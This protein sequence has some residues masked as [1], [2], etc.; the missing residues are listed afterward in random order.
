MTG[1][2]G[3][4]KG[5]GSGGDSGRRLKERL[6]TARGRTNSSQRWLQRQINDPYAAKARAEGFRSRAAYK[7]REIDDKFHIFAPGKKVIDLGA[8][9]GGWC[10]IA[11][12]RCKAADGRGAVVA[13]DLLEMGSIAGV[14]FQQMD[15][16]DDAAPAWIM[17]QIGGKADVVLSDMAP[18]TTGHK[19]TDHLR[20]MGLVELAADFATQVLAPGGFFVAKVF[21]GGAQGEVLNIL[22]R[23]FAVVKHV[24]PSSSRADSSELFLVATGFRGLPARLEQEE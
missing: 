4:G 21:Q 22:K 9:P 24:K 6:R 23:A 3:E 1:G 19:A 16:M 20:I 8:A 12:E 17:E 15:F 5:E 10:Q 2:K 11:A 14:N 7:I 18:N 13:I